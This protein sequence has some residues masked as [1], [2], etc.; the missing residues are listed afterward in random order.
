MK[1]INL[2]IENASDKPRISR[3]EY[4]KL[5]HEGKI[6]TPHKNEI[7]I[8]NLKT[9][10]NKKTMKEEKT[11]TTKKKKT[12]L[13]PWF[14]IT[15]VLIFSIIL[16]L[17]LLTIAKWK[18]DNDDIEKLEEEIEKDLIITEVEEEGDL[19]N[20]PEEEKESEVL[21]DYWY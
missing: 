5:K 1:K 19:I 15:L 12:R 6:E 14:F 17:N 11:I 2:D 8:T 18:N 9:R 7:D 13:R 3:S 20:P 4:Q 21:S 16:M 10:E